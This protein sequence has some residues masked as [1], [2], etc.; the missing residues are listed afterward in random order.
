VFEAHQETFAWSHL[1]AVSY[2][3]S[4]KTYGFITR[5]LWEEVKTTVKQE[6][7]CKC[8]RAALLSLYCC[9][10]ILDL[11]KCG[12]LGHCIAWV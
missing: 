5:E 3:P 1:N 10:I 4:M 7:Q 12:L 9:C 8:S 11:V 2:D 6:S